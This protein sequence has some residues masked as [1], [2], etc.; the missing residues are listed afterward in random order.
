MKYAGRITGGVLLMVL[1]F[2]V[3]HA[4]LIYVTS[5]SSYPTIQAGLDACSAGDIV[6]V[7]N[8]TYYENLIWPDVQG[9]R[10]L[11][12]GGPYFTRIDGDTVGSVIQITTGV[13]ST[14]VI[15]GFNIRNGYAGTG[16]GIY[17][18]NSSPTISNNLINYNESIDSSGG[19]GGIYCFNA[20][21]VITGNHFAFNNAAG[22]GGDIFCESNSSPTI[23]DN[24][25]WASRS[26]YGG[27]I[28]L[29][30]SSPLIISNSFSTSHTD[31]IGGGTV[32]R[33]GVCVE[34]PYQR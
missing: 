28:C 17:C 22:A 3:S 26:F 25:F 6:L 32:Y 10:L 11:A 16:G 19:G 9:I 7:D 20:S 27:A 15:S 8:G 31:S 1:L 18:V 33:D 21:P 4:A 5:S 29:D 2:T 34:P 23:A 14:T 12:E 24:T 30:A 13:D